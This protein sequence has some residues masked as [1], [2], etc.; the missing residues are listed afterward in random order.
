MG[1]TNRHLHPSPLITAQVVPWIAGPSTPVK[2]H[3][4]CPWAARAERPRRAQKTDGRER[5]EKGHHQQLQ[6]W[7]S[8]DFFN[9]NDELTSRNGRCVIRNSLVNF[10]YVT[11]EDQQRET[12]SEHDLHSW[13]HFYGVLSYIKYQWVNGS[14][15]DMGFIWIHGF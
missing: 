10:I 11:V 14:M 2:W 6:R 15:E 13:G 3:L 7:C 9:Q 4:W 1:F 5:E 12:P 8:W